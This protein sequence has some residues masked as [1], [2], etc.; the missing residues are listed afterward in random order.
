MPRTSATYERELRELLR[1]ESDALRR[2]GRRLPPTDRKVLESHAL[3]PFLVVR[4]AGS[5]G[6]DLVALRPEFAFPLEVK[7]SREATIRFSAASGRAHQQLTAHRRAVERVGLM[8]VYAY[9]RVGG[10]DEDAWRLFATPGDGG[11]GGSLRLLRRFLPSVAVTKEGNGVLRWDEGRPLLE[12]LR[13]VSF[14]TDRSP[15]RVAG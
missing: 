7:A 13:Q 3:R 12:F 8:A 6:F 4:A 5:L 9:R 11:D 14:L 10:P 15:A 1:G 2:Y